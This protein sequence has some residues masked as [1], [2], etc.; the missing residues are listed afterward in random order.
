[1]I[2]LPHEKSVQDIRDNVDFLIRLNPNYTLINVLSLYPHTEV[3]KQALAK[4]LAKEGEWERFSL[5]PLNYKFRVEHWTEYVSEAELVKLQRE[6]YK[7]FYFRPRYIW[8][9]IRTI[10]T[11]HE[12]KSKMRGVMKLLSMN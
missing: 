5:D 10:T 3:H 12:L 6:S 9:S 1:M 11:A 8:N 2:G 4:G 7:R